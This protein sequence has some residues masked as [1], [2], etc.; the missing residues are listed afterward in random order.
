MA[1]IAAAI[2]CCGGGKISDSR[3]RIP[4][5][6]LKWL[7]AVYCSRT[8]QFLLSNLCAIFRQSTQ[9]LKWKCMKNC[10]AQ[11]NW[12]N[13]NF[14]RPITI[15]LVCIL[16]VIQYKNIFMFNAA[17]KMKLSLA[18]TCVCLGLQ[19]ATILQ[20]SNFQPLLLFQHNMIIKCINQE[21]SA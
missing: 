7:K 10:Y 16:Y 8:N 17:Q 15:N 4:V 21:L 5:L 2:A 6:K 11:V 12:Y 18:T 13:F 9:K 1:S 3:E 20:K 14:M 19:F